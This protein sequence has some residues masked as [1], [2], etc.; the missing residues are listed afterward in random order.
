MLLLFVALIPL[1][2]VVQIVLAVVRVGT[3]QVLSH[4]TM[5]TAINCVFRPEAQFRRQNTLFWLPDPLLTLQDPASLGERKLLVSLDH[6]TSGLESSS[7]DQLN[8]Y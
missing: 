4:V 6:A 1:A 8:R 7:L 3:E 2:R 5:S